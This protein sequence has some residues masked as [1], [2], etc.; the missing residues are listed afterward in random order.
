[1]RQIAKSM[2]V[3]VVCSWLWSGHAQVTTG[4]IS[5]TVKDSTDAVLPGAKVVVLNEETGASR[6]A[7]TDATGHYLAPSINPGKYKVTASLE[8]FQ[9]EVRSG[10]VLTI[11]RQAVVD[12]Q[13][14]VGAV[15]QTVEVTGEAPL[16]E[17]T[18]SSVS[19]LVDS[20]TITELPLNGRSLSD[21][22]L[23]QPG[24]T[25]LEQAAVATHRGYGTQINIS[26]ARSD[27]NVFLLDGTDIADYQNNAPVGPN[28]IMYG[29]G[30]VREFQVQTNNFSAQY[31]HSMGGVFN[32]VSKS[33]TNAFSG[34]VFEFLRNSAV[35]A[36]NFFDVGD[37]PPF[38]RN[39][40]GGGLG[41]PLIRDKTFFHGSYEGLRESR[42]TTQ[43]PLVPGTNL[44]QGILPD[45]RRVQVTPVAAS[46]I[47]FFPQPTPGGRSFSDGTAEYI[48]AT[49]R[50][51]RSDYFQVRGDHNLSEQDSFFG[52]FTFLDLERTNY[53]S[54]PGHVT[55][56]G[57]G[58]RLA[59][60]SETHIFSARDLNTFRLAFNR[61]AMV[62][63]INT[64]EIPPL[65]YFPD[66]ARPGALSIPGL[67][68]FGIFLWHEF[69]ATTNRFEV[70]DDMMLS[71]ANH[72]I[73]FGG[74]FQRLQ[75]NHFFPNAPNGLYVFRSFELFLQGQ[76]AALF[77]GSPY[78]LGNWVRG[79]RSWYFSAYIQDDWRVRPNLTLNLGL[80]Y[81]FG[82]VPTEVNG[83]IVGFRPLVPKADF[84]AAGQFVVGDPLWLNPSAKDFAPRIGFAWTP[85]SE[86]SLAVRGGFG[87]FYGRLDNRHYWANRDGF[88]G[89]GFAVPNP[90]HFPNGLAEL[91]AEQTPQVFT[92]VYD[93]LRTPHALQWT[94]NVQQQL[95][96]ST[97]LSVGYTGTR[98]LNLAGISN[99]NAPEARFID[100]VLTIPQG[101]T[102]R[103]RGIETIDLTCTC[104]DSW[105]HSLNVG[106]T[107][108]LSSGLQFQF[109]YTWSKAMSTA[110]QTSRAQ[111][112]FN[113]T[114]GY[115]LDPAH[116]DADKSLS[117][118]DARQVLKVNY[119]YQLPWG[120]DRPWLQSGIASH[121]LG[122]WQ[123]GGILTLKSGSP[124]TLIVTTSS[125]LSAVT[126]QVQRPIVKPGE[127]VGGRVLGTPADTCNGQPC[128]SY[129]D[130]NSFLFP[131]ALQL[132][133]V[134]RDTAITPGIAS[135]DA[136]IQKTFP[137][138][139]KIGLQFRAEAF[140]L[141]NRV[142]FGLPGSTV[143]GPTGRPIGSTGRI[144]DTTVNSREFQ[145]GLK[146][147][148]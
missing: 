81:D 34:E 6:T 103:N 104:A 135:F 19:T 101:A 43:R 12:F 35:D 55:I 32:A 10:I 53:S 50:R 89:K 93:S 123:L 7:V 40:F 60:L 21:L 96:A 90:T 140:N 16:V 122:G 99:P 63:V 114:S 1:M 41:G 52:R 126:A 65:K 44:R 5:G 57:N 26:G 146:L 102:R 18:Q 68:Q 49:P 69:Y 47:P 110:D 118:W 75:G 88:I 148:F 15:T 107:R 85:W 4:T 112:T 39:Q 54:T 58:S 48:V 116:I 22:V 83:K 145:F 33:G 20:T 27:D 105:Y 24:V 130:P 13:L 86:R 59:T 17:T 129:Y 139:E 133:N 8:G 23:L 2:L 87:L 106:L 113:R 144:E 92:T 67:M 61:N 136:S 100:G 37:V 46:I 77:R 64:P 11:G 121:I 120:P 115:F 62:E 138:G 109:A 111:L 28:G 134:G 141:F 76:G 84:A 66:A 70:G 142:N 119:V 79:M 147:A 74:D 3:V 56:T 80:R 131:G 71:R 9:T 128:L 117:P 91:S 127:P 143:F 124:F 72:S 137:F 95:G 97:V 98:G 14:Q 45:G 51:D 78:S 38:R 29:A 94:L 31:G 125:A 73:Q 30:S 132:G 108:R 25:K 42:T 82:S 36:R